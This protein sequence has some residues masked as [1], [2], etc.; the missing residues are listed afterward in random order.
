MGMTNDP[1]SQD[2][3]RMILTPQLLSSGSAVS[4][5]FDL[6]ATGCQRVLFGLGVGVG[7]IAF[8]ATNRFDFLLLAG[9]DPGALL[10]IL[11]SVG[12]NKQFPITTDGI[13]ASVQTPAPAGVLHRV[14][15]YQRW[16]Y[17]QVQAAAIGVH[18]APT[19]VYGFCESTDAFVAPVGD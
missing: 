11:A 1:Y 3:L 7:G 2:V 8:N 15:I 9:D 12:R 4:P 16:R 17:W 13:L 6:V 18:G 10:P 19:I 5:I 14:G